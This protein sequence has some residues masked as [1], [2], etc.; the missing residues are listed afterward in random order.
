VQKSTLSRQ[1]Q[2]TEIVTLIDKWRCFLI[3]KWHGRGE[4]RCDTQKAAEAS[5][6]VLRDVC[7][8]GTLKNARSFETATPFHAILD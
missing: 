1:N 7:K 6:D 8:S 2:P 4:R 5:W 3:A